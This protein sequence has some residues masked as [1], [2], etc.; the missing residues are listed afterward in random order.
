MTE[1][2]RNRLATLT[3]RLELLRGY[4]R[5]PL[6]WAANQENVVRLAVTWLLDDWAKEIEHL[7]F[8]ETH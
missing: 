8:E 1:H 2:E 7:R 5:E 6:A 3:A 4:S